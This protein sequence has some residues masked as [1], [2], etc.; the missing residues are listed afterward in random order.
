MSISA[1]YRIEQEAKLDNIR[2]MPYICSLFRVGIQYLMHR[3][4]PKELFVKSAINMLEV[5]SEAGLR[6]VTFIDKSQLFDQNTSV[7]FPK[8]FLFFA[9]LFFFRR[10]LIYNEFL[11]QTHFDAPN[12]S[13]I[14]VT[15]LLI[16]LIA[17][18]MIEDSN[19]LIHFSESLPAF[20]K[21][22]E[23][24][25]HYLVSFSHYP[26]YLLV[27]YFLKVLIL[28][29]YF[30]LDVYFGVIELCLSTRSGD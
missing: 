16:F 9:I 11:Q 23:V 24:C 17:N 12:Y 1:K 7:L 5:F 20:S 3:N 2:V 28:N 19:Y 25:A 10:L 26:F 15:E 8:N 22:A 13:L 14:L 27:V 21:K 18:G 6:K 30:R 29:V 4:L